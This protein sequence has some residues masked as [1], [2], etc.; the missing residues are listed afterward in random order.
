MSNYHLIIKPCY[1]VFHMYLSQ[2]NL[3][4]STQSPY[5]P[6]RSVETAVLTFE[7]AKWHLGCTRLHHRAQNLVPLDFSVTF[8][9]IEAC[10]RL[11]RHFS[12]DTML[13]RNA[14][15]VVLYLDGRS[16]PVVIPDMYHLIRVVLECGVFPHGSVAGPIAFTL[17]S[18]P[19]QDIIQAIKKI[20]ACIADI[21]SWREVPIEEVKYYCLEW[22]QDW[23]HLLFI[24]VCW[25]M[26]VSHQSR[27]VT[28]LFTLQPVLEL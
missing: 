3:H 7:S 26:N 24:W 28:L 19:L 13:K 11:D 18:A 10:Q 6:F 27:L 21:R 2:N 25:F 22:S 8:D 20:M 15:M 14:W 23:A 9:L 4:A 12:L 17:F 5:R 1:P 16:Q